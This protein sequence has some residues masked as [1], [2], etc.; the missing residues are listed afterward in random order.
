MLEKVKKLRSTERGRTIFKLAL[1]M[2]FFIF[3]IVLVFVAKSMGGPYMYVP[4]GNESEESRSEESSPKTLSFY[5]K[6]KKLL[7]GSHDFDYKISG[8]VKLEYYGHYE[9]GRV[10]GFKETE[11]DLIK[12]SIED[13]KIYLSK[14]GQK[15]EYDS[16]YEGLDERYFNLENLFRELNK[17]SSTIESESESKIYNYNTLDN[18]ERIRVYTDDAGIFFIRIEADSIVYELNFKY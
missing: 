18:R 3:V 1:Y 11:D 15:E 14:F 5:E 12:Y 9:K 2:I 10:D 17:T 8:P 6:Q 7:E 13:G 4:T 16:L